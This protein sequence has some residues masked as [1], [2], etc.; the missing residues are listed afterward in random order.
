VVLTLFASTAPTLCVV[1]NCSCSFLFA[2][3]VVL[4]FVA[5]A[6]PTLCVVKTAPAVFLSAKNNQSKLLLI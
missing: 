5:S 6:A 2:P 3:S 4:T 1:E